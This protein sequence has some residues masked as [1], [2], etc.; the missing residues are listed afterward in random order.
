MSNTTSTGFTP[1]S[2][3]DFGMPPLNEHP[4]HPGIHH[5]M[6]SVDDGVE[7][8]S[9]F[10]YAAYPNNLVDD[11]LMYTNNTIN[12][13]NSIDGLVPQL[14]SRH[15]LNNLRDYSNQQ[16]N[17]SSLNVVDEIPQNHAQLAD[18]WLMYNESGDSTNIIKEEV[19]TMLSQGTIHSMVEEEQHQQF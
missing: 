1:I 17:M 11:S 19:P 7:P 5:R 18:S 9:Q 10:G 15:S 16:W 8:K 3:Y 13:G 14:E 6:N 2:E 4:M 12:L